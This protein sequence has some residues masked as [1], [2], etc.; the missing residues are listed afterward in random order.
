MIVSYCRICKGGEVFDEIVK[1]GRFNER[2]AAVLMKQVLACI[3]F[4]HT[5]NIIHRDLKPENVL[6]EANKDFNAIK[7]IDFGEAIEWKSKANIKQRTGTAMYVAPEVIKKS[8]NSKCDIW[9]CGIMMC[10]LVTG[11]PP[12][13]GADD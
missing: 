8:Y 6:L 13:T 1:R 3:N 4:C 11:V 9:S 7:M 5:N 10:I 2:D 12:I